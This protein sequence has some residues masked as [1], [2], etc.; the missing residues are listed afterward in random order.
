MRKFL[1][2][3]LAVLAFSGLFGLQSAFSQDCSFPT[4][5]FACSGGYFYGTTQEIDCWL[6]QLNEGI[7]GLAGCG[8]M[9]DFHNIDNDIIISLAVSCNPQ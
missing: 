4:E 3:F 7:C 5:S 6:N 1:F 8:T 9:W 2:S